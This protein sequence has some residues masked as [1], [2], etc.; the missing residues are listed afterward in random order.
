MG[1]KLPES[2]ESAKTDS[3]EGSPVPVPIAESPEDPGSCQL[4]GIFFREFCTEEGTLHPPTL[5]VLPRNPEIFLAAS[6]MGP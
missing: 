5:H 4:W 1:A 2:A 3:L 6:G